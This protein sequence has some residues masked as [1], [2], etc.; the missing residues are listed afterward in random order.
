MHLAITDQCLAFCWPSLSK[1]NNKIAPFCW[2]S[3]EERQQYMDEN[4]IFPLP[5]FTTGPPPAAPIHPIL[6][7]PSIL[8]LVAAIVR[9][10]DRLFFVSCKFGNNDARER[11]LAWV[12]FMDSICFM[13]VW[14]Q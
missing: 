1:L 13:Q 6:A 2:E 11:L 7:V 5:A 9:S 14:R 12:A 8:L 3:N 10:T 4:N